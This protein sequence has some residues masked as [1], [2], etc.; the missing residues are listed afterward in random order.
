MSDGV[1]Q[2]LS[3]EEMWERLEP[4]SRRA[5][6]RA[7]FKPRSYPAIVCEPCKRGG[8]PTD[9]VRPCTRQGRVVMGDSPP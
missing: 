9:C 3:L 6:S 1:P 7:T 5:L 4:H 2:Q 8:G